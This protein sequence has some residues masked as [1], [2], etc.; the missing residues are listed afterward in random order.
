MSEKIDKAIRL[1][2]L[3]VANGAKESGKEIL[4]I[5]AYSNTVRPTDSREPVACPPSHSGL[6]ITVSREAVQVMASA[7]RAY[8][9]EAGV[10][11]LCVTER[12]R[13]RYKLRAYREGAMDVIELLTA[14]VQA[15][16]IYQNHFAGN[17]LSRPEF[18]EVTD[19]YELMG[20]LF[21]PRAE[22]TLS[23]DYN[24]VKTSALCTF[25]PCL[26]G[27]AQGC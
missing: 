13:A 6:Y 17:G 15:A 27:V 16:H 5:P 24:D 19:I 1:W 18:G 12:K 3:D 7:S 8:E 14:S 23:V 21:E 10:C 20:G 26:E 4:V 9:T 22:V 2:A 25:E 11:E